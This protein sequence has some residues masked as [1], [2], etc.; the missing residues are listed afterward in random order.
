MTRED[1]TGHRWVFSP[2]RKKWI[3]V[4]C[5]CP[6]GGAC[7]LPD[8]L[9]QL[10]DSRDVELTARDWR[11]FREKLEA[12]GDRVWDVP[13]Y[14]RREEKRLQMIEEVENE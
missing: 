9:P 2:K 10:S 3:K 4:Y 6:A 7:P 1:K 12:L 8:M 14:Y 5:P 13:G 11:S